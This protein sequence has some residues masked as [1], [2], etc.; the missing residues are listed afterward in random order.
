MKTATRPAIPRVNA[1]ATP[2]RETLQCKP[3]QGWG[4]EAEES[5][6]LR[7]PL[8]GSVG[9]PPSQAPEERNYHIF[10]CMLLG[11][12]AEEKQLLGLGTPSEYRYLTMVRPAS[13]HAP[14]S[15]PPH[16]SPTLPFPPLPAFLPPPPGL[17]IT[18]QERGRW[19]G[20]IGLQPQKSPVWAGP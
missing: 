16:P 14:F 17:S 3:G 18:N 13:R 4:Q 6:S 20:A 2:G 8:T 10:Y 19:A 5:R 7:A 12:S 15:T 1:R 9:R 11:M